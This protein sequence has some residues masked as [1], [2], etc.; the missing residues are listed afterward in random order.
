MID[1]EYLLTRSHRDRVE[2]SLAALERLYEIESET[3]ELPNITTEDRATLAKFAGAGA[4]SRLFGTQQAPVWEESARARLRELLTEE[5]YLELQNSCVNAF[6]T[7]PDVVDAI[8]H[9]AIA[10]G[11]VGGRVLD[12]GCGIGQFLLFCPEELRSR[13]NYVGVDYNSVSIRIAKLLFPEHSW[14]YRD[15]MTWACPVD[16]FDL[17]IGN[18]PFEDGTFDSYN[19]FPLK[20]G[21]HAR[22]FMKVVN[23]LKP[24]QLCCIQTSTGTLDSVGA[25]GE[26]IQ[27]RQYLEHSARFLG[28]VRLPRDT[29]SCYGT[30][31]TTDVIL[32]R[33][34]RDGDSEPSPNWIQTQDS[35][36]ISAKTD[37]PCRI[38]EYFINHPDRLIGDP[39]LDKLTGDKFALHLNCINELIPRMDAQLEAIAS[40]S[41]Q[42]IQIQSE[43][44]EETMYARE[45]EEKDWKGF[46]VT[47]NEEKNGIEIRFPAPPPDAMRRSLSAERI[48]SGKR[49]YKLD[50]YRYKGGGTGEEDP[51][52]VTRFTPETAA[53]AQTFASKYTKYGATVNLP[54]IDPHNDY[55]EGTAVPAPQPQPIAKLETL[56][57]SK[58]TER[59]TGSTAATAV[60]ESESLRSRSADVVSYLEQKRQA[61]PKAEPPQQPTSFMGWVTQLLE[62]FNPDPLY[63]YREAIDRDLAAMAEWRESGLWRG[64]PDAR[65]LN[66]EFLGNSLLSLIVLLYFPTLIKKVK[67]KLEELGELEKEEVRKAP[68]PEDTEG[69]VGRFN[70]KE[71]ED[72]SLGKS[73]GV[74]EKQERQPRKNDQLNSS[75]RRNLTTS[76]LRVNGQL[77]E[78]IFLLDD[79]LRDTEGAIGCFAEL[80]GQLGLSFK[81]L[82]VPI[83]IIYRDE[84]VTIQPGTFIPIAT[85]QNVGAI[86]RAFIGLYQVQSALISAQADPITPEFEIDEL[87]QELNDRYDAFV[88]R[89]GYI[90]Q[91]RKLLEFNGT[92]DPRLCI[93]PELESVSHGEVSKT[94]IFYDRLLKPMARHEGQ[95]FFDEDIDVRL[96]HALHKSRTENIGAI[97]LDRIAELAGVTAEVAE[98]GLVRLGL[99][100]R[101]PILEAR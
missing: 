35:V 19:G 67:Q 98:E 31:V 52:W 76:K 1:P 47:Y 56:Q 43:E 77:G 26:N 78:P 41:A 92:L 20:V 90:A 22:F 57:L 51:R 36:I 58:Q 97:D 69:A 37:Q 59:R 101:M 50:F 61:K 55:L 48:P 89:F 30:E 94:P 4:I 39:V 93:L 44:N 85:S 80:N 18:I 72:V 99:L 12:P 7:P 88:A 5:D 63:E 83:Q 16:R 8:W 66:W 91:Y 71:E 62:S 25:D 10:N 73:E 3:P 40:A 81:S 46:Q 29:C 74:G 11:F 6:Y 28:A 15:F 82:P 60:A 70:K 65:T 27:F 86:L 84:P 14:Y 42:P 23:L 13:I 33:K 53:W 64:E 34:R 2:D 9:G 79:E 45:A 95:F 49:Q 32:L 24:G 21:L 96:E 68:P 54:P 17:A 87:R 75:N 38:N 100:V